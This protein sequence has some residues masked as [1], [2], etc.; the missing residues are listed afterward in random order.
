MDAITIKAFNSKGEIVYSE[1][2]NFTERCAATEVAAKLT[3][4]HVDKQ[5]DQA[6]NR[7]DE[8]I[9]AFNAGSKP[10]GST[11]EE[12]EFIRRESA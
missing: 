10:R 5:P 12:D 9:A 8:L 2:L 11:N 6:G 4:Y 3:G 7:L 1:P